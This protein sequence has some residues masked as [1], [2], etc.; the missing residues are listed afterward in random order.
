MAAASKRPAGVR[1]PASASS[2]TP[3]PSSAVALST[4]HAHDRLCL[5]LLVLV[6]QSV[7][8]T[9]K[10]G[11]RVQGILSAA[12]TEGE[13]SV[14]LRHVVYLATPTSPNPD[15]TPKSSLLVNAKDLLEI[16]AADVVLDP[17]STSK[18]GSG[19]ERAADSFRTDTDISGLPPPSRPRERDLQAW[20]AGADAWGAGALDDGSNG[21]GGLSLDDDLSKSTSNGRRGPGGGGGNSGGW[22]Q[23]AANERMYGLKT[24]YDEEIYTTKLD[25]NTKD[26]KDREARAAQLEREI[27]K[28]TSGLASNAHMAE[29]RGEQVDDDNVNEED[30]YGAVQRNPGAYVPPG[31]R[32]AALARLGG[33]S[34][35]P[36]STNGVSPAPDAA[37]TANPT[38]GSRIPPTVRIPG[39]S[40][41]SASAAASLTP[42]K[43]HPPVDETFRDFVREEKERL[44]KKKAALLQQQAKAEKDNR[45][46]S[47]VQFSQS[48]KNPYP[49]TDEIANMMHGKKTTTVEPSG[50]KASSTTVSPAAAPRQLPISTVTN[51][52]KLAA[53]S[54]AESA[55]AAAKPAPSLAKKSLL[56]ADIPPFNPAKA[57]ARQAELAAQKAAKEGGAA[58]SAAAISAAT[59]APTPAPVAG[60]SAL[61]PQPPKSKIS[62]TAAP[63]VF[64]PNPNASSFTPNSSTARK[65]PV[66]SP[67]PA[68]SPKPQAQ[69]APVASSSAAP[70]NP[71]FGTKTL[72]RAGSSSLN[73]KEDFTPFRLN[74]TLPEPGQAVPSWPFTGKPY[75]SMYPPQATPLSL[76]DEQSSAAA[77]YQNAVAAQMSGLDP[78]ISPAPQPGLPPHHSHQLAMH[79]VNG[80]GGPPPPPPGPGIP[81]GMPFPGM[82]VH[83]QAMAMNPAAVQAAMA[84]GMGGARQMYGPPPGQMNGQQGPGHARGQQQQQQQQQQ[85]SQHAPHQQ[86]PSQQQQQQQQQQPGQMA[87][88]PSPY[89][90]SAMNMGPNGQMFAAPMQQGGNPHMF[91]SPSMQPQPTPSG[92][93]SPRYAPYHPYANGPPPPPPP[94]SV[95]PPQGYVQGQQ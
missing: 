47:L 61:T 89:H 91:T 60:G 71:F 59:T 38:S 43:T 75:R 57:A 93:P 68:P 64:K 86:H 58:T 82:N 39:A 73:V 2:S 88:V 13:L 48:F 14:A 32:K 80:Q 65:P 21:I 6:G 42:A 10:G 33:T 16:E 36:P 28:G 70:S 4:Q 12:T 30:R 94:G 23:F 19:Q 56:L 63:F 3:A 69:T 62:A 40:N 83:P 34:P 87:F 46:R 37:N 20:S 85:H 26:Y 15:S 66:A 31:A 44:E 74:A 50:V 52:A 54:S 25:R 79:S 18:P 35:T 78:S 9:L 11:V 45:L 29:E 55:A 53:P 17:A 77:A 84:A 27:L 51:G 24:D 72:K 8:A 1:A 49:I 90:M 67:S 22:D 7:I 81:M 5:L 41:G 92:Q 95:P 76:A